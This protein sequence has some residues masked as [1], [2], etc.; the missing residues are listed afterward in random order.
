[1]EIIING[2]DIEGCFSP[3][4]AQT[5]DPLAIYVLKNYLGKDAYPKLFFLYQRRFGIF[6]GGNSIDNLN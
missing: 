1:M 4:F 3:G 2:I 5:P 6:G